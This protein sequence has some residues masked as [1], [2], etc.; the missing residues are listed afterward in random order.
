MLCYHLAAWLA[1][2]VRHKF[3]AMSAK[4]IYYL[5]MLIFGT[6]RLRVRLATA[7]D[8]DLLHVLWTD[9][10]VMT[11][12]GFPQGLPISRAEIVA[13]LQKE[14]NLAVCDR[15]LI[16]E[17]QDTGEAIG[18]CKLGAPNDAGIAETDVKLLPR[19]WGQGYGVELKRGLVNYLF[20]HTD[21]KA[22]QATPNVMNQASIQMQEAVGGVRV[23][24]TLFS[25]PES[26]QH[27][28]WPVHAFVYR[29]FRDDWVAAQQF[30][31]AASS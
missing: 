2:A 17:R 25:F 5:A 15:Y 3:L 18:E 19:F 11:Y 21:C 8:A 23:G 24:E 13:I 28:T 16:A 29:V 20:R 14:T 30:S 4:V 7:D 10:R 22:V 31:P 26:M 1:N 9:P 27:Y 6:E 12:V